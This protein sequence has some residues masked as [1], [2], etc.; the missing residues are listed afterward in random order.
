MSKTEDTTEFTTFCDACVAPVLE[1]FKKGD[2]DLYVSDTRGQHIYP[3]YTAPTS[4]AA[5]DLA[6][7]AGWLVTDA[8]GKGSKHTALCSTHR[9]GK[10]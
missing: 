1:A 9:G 5:D 2:V 8:D 4:G 10:P 7:A 3:H 6:R